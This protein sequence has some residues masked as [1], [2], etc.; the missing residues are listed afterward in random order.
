MKARKSMN[1]RGL[2]FPVILISGITAA[3][4]L[5]L[6][7]LVVHRIT[8]VWSPSLK[9]AERLL[10]KKK[11]AEALAVI[12]KAENGKEDKP[13]LLV[14]KGR[15]WFSL[16][17]EREKRSRWRDYGTDESNWLKSVEAEKALRC[18]KKALKLDPENTEAHYLL[19]QLYMEKGW[20]SRAETEF[21]E[22]LRKKKKH[23]NALLN[24][25]VTYTQMRRLDLAERELRNA[26]VM[27]PDDPAV[28]KN[29]AYLYRFYLDKPDSAIAWANRYLNLDPQN[30]LDINFIRNELEDMLQRYPEYTPSEP[31]EWKKP[32]KFKSRFGKSED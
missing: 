26:Y 12:E 23:V 31:M 2:S 22:V 30:D 14:E 19:G 28:A 20:Y 6:G 1:S 8:R 13:A 27:A 32:R 15:I 10:Q 16:A 9:N 29:F 3:F 17:L 7:L 18:F 11:Y 5:L 21:L 4:F 24:L 25:G